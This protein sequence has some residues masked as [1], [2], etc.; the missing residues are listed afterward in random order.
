[1]NGLETRIRIPLGTFVRKNIANSLEETQPTTTKSFKKIRHSDTG[2]LHK[3][4]GAIDAIS[5]YHR[6]DLEESGKAYKHTL[7][8]LIFSGSDVM[9]ENRF[10]LTRILKR[11]R[12]R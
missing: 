2:L 4:Q 8:R 6:L 3:M 10:P 1:V 9:I 5:G 12:T 11:I 7:E